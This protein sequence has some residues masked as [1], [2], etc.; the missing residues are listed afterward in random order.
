MKKVF[1]C[2]PY[3]TGNT[4][5]NVAK[6]KEHCREAIQMGYI[7]FAPHLYFP[8][9]TSDDDL[10]IKMGCEIMRNFDFVWVYGKPTEGM[11]KE[12]D[13]ALRHGIRV[14]YK[15]KGEV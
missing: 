4:L 8:Q 14:Y 15:N 13:Y 9:M 11:Q 1:I 7:P 3:R 5:E 12:I 10:A 2:S 6:A